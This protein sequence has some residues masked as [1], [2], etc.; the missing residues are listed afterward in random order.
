MSVGPCSE[1]V[2]NLILNISKEEKQKFQ[3][4]FVYGILNAIKRPWFVFHFIR[5]PDV[6][7]DAF[8]E[9]VMNINKRFPDYHEFIVS[10]VT[11]EV[12]HIFVELSRG[13][14]DDLTMLYLKKLGRFLGLVTLTQ[15]RIVF[16]K[17]LDMKAFLYDAILESKDVLLYVLAFMTQFLRGLNGSLIRPYNPYVIRILRVLK[18]LYDQRSTDCDIKT[19]I[20]A[21]CGAIGVKIEDISDFK[22]V[23]KKLVD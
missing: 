19:E 9:V 2:C 4:E 8:A 18:L 21:L 23:V 5:R 6:N 3:S 1:S 13:N 10:E 16:D 11:S 20:N 7:L 12:K 17:D 22:F 14:L 15:N